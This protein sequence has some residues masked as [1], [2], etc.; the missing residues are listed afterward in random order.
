L[1]VFRNIF[2][3][4]IFI[5]IQFVVITGQFV[6]V[7][8]AG[9]AFGTV[10]LNHYQ[11]LVTILIGSLSLPVGLIIRLIPNSCLPESAIN[12]DFKPK[13]SI[14][15]RRWEA[16]GSKVMQMNIFT[17]VRKHKP[18]SLPGSRNNSLASIALQALKKK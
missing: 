12:E 7:Q 5:I 18:K 8:Y 4:H 2:N 10:P 13:I 14:E 6:I 9:K 3:N 1:N 15:K 16:A 17:T 11:W